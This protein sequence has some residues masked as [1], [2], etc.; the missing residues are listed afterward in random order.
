MKVA[1]DHAMKEVGLTRS[2][3]TLSKLNQEEG[4]D[5][6][7][8]AW[9]DPKKRSSLGEYCENGVK[10]IAEEATTHRVTPDFFAQHT[11]AEMSHWTDYKIGKSG[12]LT[13]PMVLREGSEH[14]EKIFL[15]RGICYDWKAITGVG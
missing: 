11:V 7:G 8:C 12:R 14:Y 5:C 2:F 13:H 6:P 10:A 4:I 1:L 9:P 15:G 3:A